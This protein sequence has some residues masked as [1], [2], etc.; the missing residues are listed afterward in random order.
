MLAAAALCAT[1]PVS[2][3]QTTATVGSAS[4]PST[5]ATIAYPTNS[6]LKFRADGTFKVVCFGDVHWNGFEDKDKQTLKVMDSIV[7][8]EKPDFVMFT[9]D[10][11]LNDHLNK[12]REGYAQMSEPAVRRNIPWAATLGNHDGE[13][14][15]LKRREVQACS[16]GLPG[17]LSQVGPESLHGASNFLLP[18]M[19]KDNQK[20]SAIFYIFDSNSY[21]KDGIYDCYDWIHADQVQWYRDASTH[22][23][24]ANHGQPLPG[25]AFFH[26]PIPE[27]DL[28]WHQ[29]TKLGVKQ[30]SVCASEV[31]GGLWAAMLERR[32]IKGVFC[33]HDHVNDFIAGY[34]GIWLGYVR[35]I[36]YHTYGK[37]GFPKGARVIQLTQ[38][39][40]A[41]DTWLRLEDGSVANRIRCE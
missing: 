19:D 10:N 39:A 24:A 13:W 32:D 41:F 28:A 11:S 34:S 37:E 1:T 23:L 26:I 25:Y 12:V 36:S 38:G 17:S 14:G 35:G 30:E 6:P 16:V 5:A 8:A 22:Y 2:F 27:F 31:N 9:G 40:E 18:V 15:G 21:F 20:P 4:Q 33:G 29:G 7:E 3:S